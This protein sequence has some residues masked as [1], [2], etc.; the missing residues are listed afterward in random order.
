MKLIE[1]LIVLNRYGEGLTLRLFHTKKWVVKTRHSMI[2]SQDKAIARVADSLGKK[3]PEIPDL[4][5][6]PGAEE[7]VAQAPALVE[8]TTHVYELALDILNWIGRAKSFLLQVCEKFQSGLLLTK[9]PHLLIQFMT[10]ISHYCRVLILLS[11]IPDR[12]MLI[13][14]YFAGYK[15]TQNSSL[16]CGGDIDELLNKYSDPIKRI[17]EDFPP[18]LGQ[19]LYSSLGGLQQCIHLLFSVPEF[20]RLAT[21]SLTSD[22]GSISI[23]SL[24]GMSMELPLLFEMRDWVIFSSIVAPEAFK[25]EGGVPSQL[26]S[27]V[28]HNVWAIRLV[29]NEMFLIHSPLVSLFSKYKDETGNLC[30][31]KYRKVFSSALTECAS[32]QGSVKYQRQFQLFL[33]Q[34]L[35]NLLCILSDFPAL[36]APKFSVV[37][38]ALSLA[39]NLVLMHYEHIHFP[40]PSHK[41]KKGEGSS[42]ILEIIHLVRQLA[43][44]IGDHRQDIQNYYAEYLKGHHCRTLN[45]HLDSL[46]PHISSQQKKAFE[47]A[48]EILKSIV[49]SGE[50]EYTRVNFQALRL[51]LMRLEVALSSSGTASYANGVLE[52]I[53]W[54]V[55]HSR[56]LDEW[57]QTLNEASSFELLWS[58]STQLSSDFEQTLSHPRLSEF[59]MSIF[60]V[61]H[62]FPRIATG[63]FPQEK[64]T[65]AKYCVEFAEQRC[66]EI[67]YATYRL[68]HDVWEAFNGWNLQLDPS[69]IALSALSSL[70][71]SKLDRKPIPVA[72][73]SDFKNYGGLRLIDAKQRAL[74]HLLHAYQKKTSYL[75]HDFVFSPIEYFR[76][77]LKK[78]FPLSSFINNNN[79]SRPN[80]FLM[81]KD[82]NDLYSLFFVLM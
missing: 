45:A 21:L 58:Y 78:V 59:A 24:T 80:F 33:I 42:Q 39:K 36:F 35:R 41:L 30:L 70:P 38:G 4:D 61:L 73:E 72:W 9:E 65:I 67:A 43:E 62:H 79:A 15:L 11:E 50:E 34:E 25:D 37:L 29:R 5:K 82:G 23:P 75:V 32:G 10:L 71:N 60:T 1:G 52:R 17:H 13:A 3:F 55:L 26:L 74:I 56:Y 40:P 31:K 16:S 69:N 53:R 63:H 76:A 12:R 28:L 81:E 66:D 77:I 22:K 51:N 54:I 46:R 57:Q 6:Q 14:V 44:L 18:T 27:L 49:G 47:S 19:V 68:L 64:G 2:L 20:R 8:M 48:I 7:F